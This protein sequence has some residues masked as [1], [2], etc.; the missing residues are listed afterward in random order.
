M[1]SA[2]LWRADLDRRAEGHPGLLRGGPPARRRPGG[3]ATWTR[4]S[5]PF[6]LSDLPGGHVVPRRAPR[7]GRPAAR[8]WPRASWSTP[9]TWPDTGRDGPLVPDA[10]GAGPPPAGRGPVVGPPAALARAA[11]RLFEPEHSRPFAAVR[12]LASVSGKPGPRHLLGGWLMAQLDL[13]ARELVLTDSK[14]VDIT[15]E[16]VLPGRRGHL[17]GQPGRRQPDGLRPR[18]SLSERRSSARARPMPLPDDP[19]TSALSVGHNQP[20][21]RPGLGTRAVG[22]RSSGRRSVRVSP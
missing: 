19:L 18:P 16:A 10:P 22:G 4:W 9:G 17:P 5:R 20:A 15:L 12:P 1:P 21:G 7:P 14:H 3:L 8:G 6:I 13:R 11:G 2:F